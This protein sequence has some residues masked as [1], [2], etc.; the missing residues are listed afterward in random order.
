MATWLTPFS[1]IWPPLLSA[2]SGACLARHAPLRH[3]VG[4]TRNR[5][6]RLR[7]HREGAAGLSLPRQAFDQGIGFTPAKVWWP[8]TPRRER[9]WPAELLP[10]EW[11]STRACPAGVPLETRGVPLDVKPGA[12]L[13][14]MRLTW[15]AGRRSSRPCKAQTPYY[16][17]LP[18]SYSPSTVRALQWCSAAGR[19]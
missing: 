5:P 9:P 1:S 12:L 6:Q 19:R 13:T 4:S 3:Y 11:A 7:A 16:R 18:A 14:W 2:R 8:G 15:S 10:V 17:R